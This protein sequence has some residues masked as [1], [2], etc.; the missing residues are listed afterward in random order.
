METLRA[1]NRPGRARTE[2]P[3]ILPMQ[4][5]EELG[6]NKPGMKLSRVVKGGLARKMPMSPRFRGAHSSTR[7]KT[8]E[9]GCSEPCAPVLKHHGENMY[10]C[11]MVENAKTA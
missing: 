10:A 3:T 2:A 7:E 11:N 9:Q 8:T 1:L 6:G 5:W 4:S